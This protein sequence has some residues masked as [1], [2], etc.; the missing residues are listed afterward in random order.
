MNTKFKLDI[1]PFNHENGRQDYKENTSFE[2]GVLEVEMEYTTEE[3]VAVLENQQKIISL[4]PSIVKE[5]KEA[6]E[7]PPVVIEKKEEEE[8]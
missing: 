3:L 5:L 1:K 6:F 4:I 8:G 2:G 7:K